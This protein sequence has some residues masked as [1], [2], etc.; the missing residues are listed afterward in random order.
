MQQQLNLDSFNDNYSNL[1]SL[2]DLINNVTITNKYYIKPS[3]SY[4]E[5]VGYHTT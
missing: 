3:I 1:I 5:N 4:V 2:N